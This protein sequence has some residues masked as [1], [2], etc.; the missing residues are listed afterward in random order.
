M[1]EKLSAWSQMKY[2]ERE[3]RWKAKFDEQWVDQSIRGEVSQARNLGGLN[4]HL[5][6][7]RIG[8]R[9]EREATTKKSEKVLITK[10][11]SM[12]TTN[13]KPSKQKIAN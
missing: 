4:G 13:D 3:L 9:R 6:K 11:S 8:R 2:E 5:G 12:E 7:G 1:V 10:D